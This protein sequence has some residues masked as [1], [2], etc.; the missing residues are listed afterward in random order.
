MN[1]HAEQN[2]KEK[3]IHEAHAEVASPGH[4]FASLILISSPPTDAWQ[5]VNNTCQDEG[6]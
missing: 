2:L 5:T 6:K 1:E 3:L 4:A